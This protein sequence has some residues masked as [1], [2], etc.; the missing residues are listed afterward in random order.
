MT[1]CDYCHE[2]LLDCEAILVSRRRY[3][4][5]GRLNLARSEGRVF[6]RYHWKDCAA[7]ALEEA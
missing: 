5:G 4:K 6:Y 2:F 7:K 1:K 3:D